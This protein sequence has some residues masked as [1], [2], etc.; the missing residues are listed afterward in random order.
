MVTNHKKHREPLIHIAK[1]DN[2]S[3]VKSWL[4]RLG[5]ILL[6]FLVIGILSSV[7]TGATVRDS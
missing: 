3:G 6:G 2:L 7:L 5:A 4:I 1:R